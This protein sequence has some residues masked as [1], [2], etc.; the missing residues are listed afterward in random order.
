MIAPVV[1]V[2]H[3]LLASLITN[4]TPRRCW[5]IA[6]NVARFRRQGALDKPLEGDDEGYDK[7]AHWKSEKVVGPTQAEPSGS[8]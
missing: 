8:S 6:R 7:L 4:P 2:G 3:V 1:G 5:A